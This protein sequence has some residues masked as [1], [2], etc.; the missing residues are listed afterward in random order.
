MSIRNALVLTTAASL[1][2]AACAQAPKPSDPFQT[3][4][5]T[6][7]CTDGNGN[8][9]DD[10]LCDDDNNRGGG[11]GGGF[12][13]LYMGGGSHVPAYGSKVHGGS[14]VRAP[15]TSYSS[16]KSVV[17]RGGFGGSARASAGS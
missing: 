11:G 6:A 14:K 1:M 13:F 5:P 3:D 8:R 17:S 10:D 7:V 16:S 15:G 9:V 2:I 4:Q 12:M